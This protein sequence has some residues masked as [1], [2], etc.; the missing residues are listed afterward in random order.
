MRETRISQM[1]I[2]ETYSEH[3]TG[4]QLR[5]LS[6][7]LAC[8]RQ[9][10]TLIKKDLVNSSLKPV[11]R[12]G[13]TVA[14]VFRCLLLKQCLSVSYDRLA[15]H[16][17]ESMSYRSF[18]RLAPHLSPK[19]SCLQST[20]RSITPE[21]LESVHKMLASAWLKKG[22]LSCEQLRIDSTV[23]KRNIAHTQ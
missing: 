18:V 5:R 13:L 23:V 3:E 20:I 10:L 22:A 2:F 14:N 19:K 16:L 15:F 6:D 12:M 21:T 7:L 8:H 11:G 4:V 9:A 17:S 1:S